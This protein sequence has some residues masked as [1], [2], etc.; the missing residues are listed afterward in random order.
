MKSY[1]ASII[2]ELWKE[3]IDYS[4]ISG[5]W[6][7]VIVDGFWISRI[8]DLCRAALKPGSAFKLWIIS[9]W[10][11]ESRIPQNIYMNI[12]IYCENFNL[13]SR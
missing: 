10:D 13:D 3:K 7:A 11:Y 2:I 1:S 8:E 5:D 9:S 4:R 12:P 6:V